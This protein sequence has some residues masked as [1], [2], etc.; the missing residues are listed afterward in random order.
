MTR[1][2]YNELAKKKGAAKYRGRLFR[3][4]QDRPGGMYNSWYLYR[5]DDPNLWFVATEQEIL[6]R[7]FEFVPDEEQITLTI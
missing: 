3:V 2:E 6:S 1:K 4:N 5:V 7:E